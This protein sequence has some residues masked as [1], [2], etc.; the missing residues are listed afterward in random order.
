MSGKNRVYADI[1]AFHPEVT[2][3]CILCIIKYKSGEKIKFVVDCGLF[4]EPKYVELNKY[5][6]VKPEELD[7]VLVTHNHIDH[8]GRLPYLVKEGFYKNIYTTN[9]TK[10]LMEPALNDTCKVLKNLAKRNNQSPLYKGEDVEKTLSLVKGCDFE[11][12]IEV[13]PNVKVTFFKNG[14]LLGAALIL[15]QI[16]SPYEEDINL[17]F[18]GDYRKENTFFKVPDLPEWLLDLPI[19]IIQESTYGE[20]NSSEIY[21]CFVNNIYQATQEEKDIVIPVFSLGRAQEVAYSLRTMQDF[22]LLS[23]EYPIYLDGPLSQKYTAIY[24]NRDIGIDEQMK[25]FLPINLKYITIENRDDIIESTKPK[26]VLTSSGMGSYGPAQSH[27]PAILRRKNGLIHFTGYM[28]EGTLGRTLK[29]TSY[30]EAVNVG[31]LVV[32]KRAQVEYTNEFSAH[33]KADEMIEWLQQ[34]KNLKLVLINHGAIDTKVSFAKQV[35]EN[36]KVK[37]IGILGNDY[38]FRVTPYGLAKTLGTKFF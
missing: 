30:G 5:L 36:V 21:H 29:D 7:F 38:F 8:I 31:G 15:V 26:I 33:A 17:L 2:G 9:V 37:N 16:S 25:D 18:T 28:A 27:I 32:Q 4:Q 10:I 23:T 13:V 19:T 34:F 11:Q 1:I 20:Q 3:S 12:T 14:H 35:L 24:L 22:E 6:P